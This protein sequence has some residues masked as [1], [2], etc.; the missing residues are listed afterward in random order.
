MWSGCELS[1]PSPSD[2]LPPTSL[3]HLAST[4]PQTSAGFIALGRP[5]L[6]VQFWGTRQEDASNLKQNKD[7]EIPLGSFKFDQ[8]RRFR[9]IWRQTEV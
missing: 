3:H 8:K 4:V 9:K 1:K 2:M 5:D 6:Y 7:R